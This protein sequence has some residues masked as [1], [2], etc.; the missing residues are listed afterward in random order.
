MCSTTRPAPASRRI[1]ALVG[2]ESFSRPALRHGGPV[3]ELATDADR[4]LPGDGEFSLEPL[5]A[6]LREINYAGVV[7]VELMNPQ[8]WSVPPRQFGE[9]AIT[10]LRRVLGLASMD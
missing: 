6:R 9:V 2:G 8:L 1:C 4:I 3:R 5:I 7:S 10:A